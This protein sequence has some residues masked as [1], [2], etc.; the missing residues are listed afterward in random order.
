MSRSCHKSIIVNELRIM[1]MFHR[2]ILTKP[3]QELAEKF[4]RSSNH[5]LKDR[6]GQTKGSHVQKGYGAFCIFEVFTWIDVLPVMFN[7]EITTRNDF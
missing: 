1:N 7:Q 2:L 6:S 3:F 5:F 4:K